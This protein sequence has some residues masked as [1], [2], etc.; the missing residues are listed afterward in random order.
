[1]SA[2]VPEKDARATHGDAS[3]SCKVVKF[4]AS[5][6]GSPMYPA[7]ALT[8]VVTV[9]GAL[10]SCSAKP[11]FGRFNPIEHA[12]RTSRL[13]PEASGFLCTECSIAWWVFL[14]LGLFI[15]YFLHLISSRFNALRD[16]AASKLDET[17][18]ALEDLRHKKDVFEAE[19]NQLAARFED[20][21]VRNERL[22]GQIAEER[23]RLEQALQDERTRF[24]HERAR[25]DDER[26]NL[27]QS[28]HDARSR[29]EDSL[30][31]HNK[32]LEGYRADLTSAREKVAAYEQQIQDQLKMIE[33]L[34]ARPIVVPKSDDTS[35]Q[36]QLQELT[37][38]KAAYLQL[39]VKHEELLS[40]FQSQQSDNELL[41]AE[42]AQFREERDQ[43]EDE[44]RELERTCDLLK[45]R[46]AHAEADAKGKVEHMH[47][48]LERARR[49]NAYINSQLEQTRQELF[50][51]KTEN[52]KLV[53]SLRQLEIKLP[54]YHDVYNK[55][56]Q[57]D[58]QISELRRQLVA[59]EAELADLRGKYDIL[60]SDLSV[61]SNRVNTLQRQL[62]TERIEHVE[63]REKL[64]VRITTLTQE[65]A[66]RSSALTEAQRKVAELNQKLAQQVNIASSWRDESSRATWLLTQ[67]DMALSRSN[68]TL[69]RE[70]ERNLALA[71][72]LS[73][74]QAAPLRPSGSGLNASVLRPP[75]STTNALSRGMS[76]PLRQSTS[77]VV[78]TPL[79]AIVESS[80]TTMTATRA[81]TV[82]VHVHNYPEPAVRY[83]PAQVSSTIAELSASKSLS[84]SVQQILGQSNPA[85]TMSPGAASAYALPA[86]PIYVPPADSA[87]LQPAQPANDGF[88][89]TARSTKSMSRT[90]GPGLQL[91]ELAS[92]LKGHALQRLALDQPNFDD[93]DADVH[94]TVETL[95]NADMA[96]ASARAALNAT[97]PIS[98][99]VLAGATSLRP[100]ATTTSASSSSV[101]D[102]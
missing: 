64:N 57:C 65:L 40:Q 85:V 72:E 63:D 34:K 78:T 98:S 68:A 24:D 27:E 102:H 43:M 96:L 93:D 82:N 41:R 90:R 26:M 11:L 92:P 8:V 83:D 37:D 10:T 17:T 30:N 48:D 53:E 22:E 20:E 52:A 73:T 55:H 70:R 50:Q 4:E 18:Q 21:R 25:F 97:T 75:A 47:D 15:V 60:D 94:K 23:G 84:A 42:L 77:K 100:P 69:A 76:S 28:L 44:C 38:I 67:H 31:E 36:Q 2:S 49:E 9:F 62:E 39:G 35:L 19:L 7:L 51:H 66:E 101:Y 3:A 95:G 56:A 58:Q 13:H 33:D 80:G 86:S 99:N 61:A 46:L 88:R 79:P 29:L 59:T 14:V 45:E 87:P 89:S 1:M 12:L 74:S 16:A 81:G 32:E 6:F 91:E 71:S 5:T 54:E